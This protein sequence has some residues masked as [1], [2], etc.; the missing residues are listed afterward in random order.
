MEGLES[1]A[2]KYGLALARRHRGFLSESRPYWQLELDKDI[3][4]DASF[5][6]P[7]ALPALQVPS[8]P[9]K[10]SQE[11][12]ASL[13]SAGSQ[14]S[15]RPMPAGRTHVC[16]WTSSHPSPESP[17]AVLSHCRPGPAGVPP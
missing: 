9:L 15:R 8:L 14:V 13:L 6:P 5:S 4:T 1:Q 10:D 2:E 12:T 11:L 3:L 17:S 7:S 16:S